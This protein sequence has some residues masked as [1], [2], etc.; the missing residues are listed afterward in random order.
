MKIINVNCFVGYDLDEIR[1]VVTAE[2]LLEQM[3][4]NGV[5]ESVT[6]HTRAVVQLDEGNEDIM[7]IAAASG[8]KIKPCWVTHPYMDGIQMPKPE[9]Y[10]ALLRKERPAAVYLPVT[11]NGCPMD[12]FYCSE[13][14]EVL[15]E[16]HMPTILPLKNKAAR[17]R[18]VLPE[19]SGKYPN[20]PF[21]LTDPDHTTELINRMLLK[22][23]QNIYLCVGFFCGTGSL[24]QLVAEFGAERFLFGGGPNNLAEGGLGLVYQG[25]FSEEDK[26]KIFHKNWERLQEGIQWES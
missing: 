7:K 16:L 14:Y 25:R 6:Y 21:V 10:K 26:E 17:V 24:D 15:D 4:V 2:Q 19:V 5:T 9:D 11:K 22:K 18:E 12:D 20:I 1:P 8:G 3:A 13:L 23:R